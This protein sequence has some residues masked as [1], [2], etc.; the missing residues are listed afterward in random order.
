MC[1]FITVVVP[2]TCRVQASAVLKR[3]RGWVSE[4]RNRHLSKASPPNSIQLIS[5]RAGCDCGTILDNNLAHEI[6]HQKLAGRWRR[7][8]W[9]ET[10]IERSL[11]DKEHG[12]ATANPRVQS[13]SFEQWK[14][15]LEEL[16]GEC[17]SAGE[18][19]LILHDYSGGLDDEPMDPAGRR[20][21]ANDSILEALRTIKED[22]LILFDRAWL[23]AQSA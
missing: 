3:R 7:T 2:A 10:K 13:D 5:S 11:A 6:D 9:S 18:V 14:K 1:R 23:R 8:G 16:I 20:V 15:I 22:E 12:K 21:S 17:S 19:G 4:T